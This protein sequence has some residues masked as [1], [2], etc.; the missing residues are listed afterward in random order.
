MRNVGCSLMCLN[1]WSPAGNATW[2]RYRLFRRNSLA[3]GK[4]VNEDGL[5]DFTAS[6]HFL[7]FLSASCVEM[8]VESVSFRPASLLPYHHRLYSLVLQIKI[9]PFFLNLLLVIATEWLL[10]QSIVTM[11]TEVR[12]LFP[13]SS[14]SVYFKCS[15]TQFALVIC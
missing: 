10:Q 13:F 14:Y 11:S 12:I 1:T 2:G 9:K 8:K 4:Y 6:S 15:K 3:G 7:F 5:W